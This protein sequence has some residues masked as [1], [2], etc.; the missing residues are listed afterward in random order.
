MATMDDE[1]GL[2]VEGSSPQFSTVEEVDAEHRQEL[3]EHYGRIRG[4]FKARPSEYTDLQRTLNQ[5]RFGVN[6]D[7]YLT[8]TVTYALLGAFL[9]VLFGV[10]ATVLLST[11]GILAGLQSPVSA[12]GSVG[13]IVSENRGLVVGGVVSVSL[14]V[15]TAVSIWYARLTYP[16]SV[17]SRR[18]RAIN[19]TLPHAIV[20]MYALSHGGM[21][22][23]EVIK[24]LA[25]SQDAYGEIAREFDTV[26]RDTEL[27]GNDLYTA[28]SNARNL[29]PSDNLEQFI[30][31]MLSVLDSGGDVTIFLE[32]ESQNYLDEAEDDEYGPE[33]RGDELPEELREQEARL[34]RLREA[35]ERLDAEEQHRKDAQAEKIRQR[36]QEEE[37]SGQRKRWRKPTPPE[38]I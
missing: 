28:L 12:P 37:E 6:Y 24:E 29:T 26:V 32:D 25:N 3:R 10:G 5:A 9:G 21:N 1:V 20:Y 35:K 19:V 36:K 38:E 7:E 14:A 30:D 11:T 13:S 15:L 4:Y 8:Q 23:Y 2:Q 33:H 27:F 18:R 31:D 34:R 17:V 16:K 22:L